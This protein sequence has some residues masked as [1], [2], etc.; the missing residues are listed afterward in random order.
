[1]SEAREFDP[2]IGPDDPEFL[3]MAVPPCF[4]FMP[5]L[6]G[7]PWSG[8]TCTRGVDHDGDHVAHVAPSEMVARWP[9]QGKP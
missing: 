6:I 8:W 2:A 4:A 9:R 7:R 3:P 1:M 5:P